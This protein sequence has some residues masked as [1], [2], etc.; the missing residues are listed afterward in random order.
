VEKKQTLETEEGQPEDGFWGEYW[1]KSN[2]QLGFVC[3]G[4]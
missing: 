1:A 3:T 4:W 2:L